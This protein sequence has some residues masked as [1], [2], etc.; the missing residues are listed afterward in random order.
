M[1]VLNRVHSKSQ[2]H[3]RFKTR[4]F[5]DV[6]IVLQNTLNEADVGLLAKSNSRK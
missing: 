3:V 5:Y 4:L 6:L 2:K 1:L